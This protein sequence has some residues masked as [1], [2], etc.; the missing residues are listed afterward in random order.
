MVTKNPN[1]HLRELMIDQSLMLR[2]SVKKKK[3]EGRKVAEEE[4]KGQ[5]S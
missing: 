2:I 5:A 3:K 4:E 1:Q